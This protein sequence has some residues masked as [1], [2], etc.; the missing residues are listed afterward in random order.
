MTDSAGG[1][2]PGGGGPDP[3][4]EL[5]GRETFYLVFSAVAGALMLGL[6]VYGALTGSA[7]RGPAVGAVIMGGLAF[8]VLFGGSE[9]G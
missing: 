2:V 6:A 4:R 8:L 3:R 5:T 9:S 1:I 7:V